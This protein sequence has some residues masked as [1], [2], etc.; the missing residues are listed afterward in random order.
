MDVNTGHLVR[1]LARALEKTRH[2]YTP[3]PAS[4][5]EDA[6]RELKGRDETYVNL[7][8]AGALPAWARNKKR[9][10]RARAKL[11]KASR[12]RNRTG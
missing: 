11:A 10:N 9:K 5:L 3:I 7:N 6:E 12:K 1:D 4:L 8:Q 2:H